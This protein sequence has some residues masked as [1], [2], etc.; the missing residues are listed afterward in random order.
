MFI[1]SEESCDRLYEDLGFCDSFRGNVWLDFDPGIIRFDPMRLCATQIGR[2]LGIYLS[3]LYS[4]LPKCLDQ[5]VVCSRQA[6]F[7]NTNTQQCCA[8]DVEHCVV[9][10]VDGT[11]VIP[12]REV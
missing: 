4:V 11:V 10:S 6:I 12:I 8:R 2:Q 3:R 1:E 9:G 7:A 5:S